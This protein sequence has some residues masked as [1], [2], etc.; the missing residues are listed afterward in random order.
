M[1]APPNRGSEVV[2]QLKRVAIGR[3][4]LGPSG[5]ELGSGPDGLPSRL[6]EANFNLGVI[7]GDCSLNPFF[8]AILRG[9]DDGKVSVESAR[10][11]GMTDFLVVHHSHTWMAWRS[12][13]I[14]RILNYL[15][16]GQFVRNDVALPNA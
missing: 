11:T 15:Q 6:G 7:A 12:K 13:T 2:D 9:P 3:W 1:L 16:C 4:I 14:S 10:I 5:C 8:S